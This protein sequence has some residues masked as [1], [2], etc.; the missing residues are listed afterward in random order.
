[1][2]NDDPTQ[3]TTTNHLF[4]KNISTHLE[5]NATIRDR[6]E[7]ME[8]GGTDPWELRLT[9]GWK[10]LGEIQIRCA[11]PADQVA[12]KEFLLVGLGDES[13]Y[14]FAPYPYQGDLGPALE[15][16]LASCEQRQTLTYHAWQE[17]QII[18][19]F[20]LGNFPDPTPSL[21]IA[22]AD[23]CHGWKLG[24]L[25]MTILIA[26]GHSEGREAIELTT[27]LRNFAGFHLYGK[28]GFIHIRDKEI[29][30]ADG[31]VRVEHEMIY[32]V[33]PPSTS[34]QEVPE[35]VDFVK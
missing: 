25:F 7:W 5:Q 21:G 16:A 11:T 9:V 3:S 8:I 35:G 26:I 28:L 10:D 32:K 34:S 22:I 12:L 20:F 17:G 14:L 24:H 29:T 19:H 33:T 31:S 15:S 27:N 30:V 6:I 13:R 23:R 4:V 1:M 18:G 2:P